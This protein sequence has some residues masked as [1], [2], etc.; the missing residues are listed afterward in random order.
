MA[1]RISH[2][3][4]AKY[5][6]QRLKAQCS[7][8]TAGLQ[9]TSMPFPSLPMLTPLLGIA[10]LPLP[11]QST[12]SP[13]TNKVDLICI[14]AMQPLLN[15]ANAGE[16]VSDE[17]DAQIACIQ[18]HIRVLKAHKASCHTSHNHTVD[19]PVQSPISQDTFHCTTKPTDR[20]PANIHCSLSPPQFSSLLTSTFSDFAYK[21]V[22]SILPT[23]SA[24]P[25]TVHTPIGSSTK[26]VTET[27]TTS[28][29][30]SVIIENNNQ[31][32]VHI[33]SKPH[34]VATPLQSPLS[35]N[36]FCHTAEPIRPYSDHSPVS[37][38]CSPSPL[39]L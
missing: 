9:C 6:H 13:F 27:P 34:G 35:Q 21:E 14:P 3:P 2:P 33:G 1:H 10:E 8:T 29:C 32:L 20:S 17:I 11:S 12:S 16:D 23:A 25:L 7:A 39:Q 22:A 15:R 18:A 30:H 24:I 26:S 5:T 38:H 31:P 36:S 19:A 28:L 37:L 4:R